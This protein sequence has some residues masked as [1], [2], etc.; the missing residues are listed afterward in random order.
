MHPV[1]VPGKVATVATRG[2]REATPLRL[3]TTLYAV[4]AA[5][6]DVVSP[7]DDALVVATVEYL[8]QSWQ[9]TW[10]GTD[11]ARRKV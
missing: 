6:Q 5:L 1:M 2:R 7:E 10:P 4:M 8:L 11:Q 9:L 3:T